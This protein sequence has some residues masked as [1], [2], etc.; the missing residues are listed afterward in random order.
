ML[1]RPALAAH[2]AGRDARVR[3]VVALRRD[4]PNGAVLPDR[5]RPGMAKAR[6]RREQ[7]DGRGDL[8]RPTAQLVGDVL[9]KALREMLFEGR[10]VADARARDRHTPAGDPGLGPLVTPDT[11]L[12][13]HEGRARVLGAGR[14]QHDA[15]PREL[16]TRRRFGERRQAKRGDDPGIERSRA[17]IFERKTL[18]DLDIRNRAQMDVGVVLRQHTSSRAM[19]KHGANVPRDRRTME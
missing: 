6:Q 14:S 9:R 7:P 17:K 2:R 15:R 1:E 10:A 11:P 5:R 18:D 8:A 3:V 12:S 4:L 13:L 16:V 19:E